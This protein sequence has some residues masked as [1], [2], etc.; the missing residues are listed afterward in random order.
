MCVFFF[1]SFHA[2]GPRL[3]VA[4]QFL[5]CVVWFSCWWVCCGVG[6][7][8]PPTC[9]SFGLVFLPLSDLT[10]LALLDYRLDYIHTSIV[11]QVR[12]EGRKKMHISDTHRVSGT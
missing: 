5:P 12:E 11:K 9:T 10:L 7:L 8:V 2:S 4:S 1:F 6:D 3:A